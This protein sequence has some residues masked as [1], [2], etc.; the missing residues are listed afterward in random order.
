MKVICTLPNASELISGVKF[1][2]V[3]D[4]GMV[5]ADIDEETAEA[6]L[7]I[8][9]Y[10]LAEA[11][12]RAPKAVEKPATAPAP[13]QPTKAEKAAAEKAE[14][15]EK[16]KAEAEAEEKAKAEAEEKA[17]AELAAANTS[18]SDTQDPAKGDGAEET[19]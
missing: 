8:P 5:S 19:F 6:F 16:A 4:V 15:A 13:K 12:K 3:P 14:A 9:G 17:A 1:K 10:E 7:E 11:E 18:T 2:H